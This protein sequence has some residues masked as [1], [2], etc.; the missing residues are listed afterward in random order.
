M[1]GYEILNFLIF[2]LRFFRIVFEQ[3]GERNRA[4]RKRFEIYKVSAVIINKIDTATTDFHNKSARN[5]HTVYNALIYKH[6]LFFNRQH[7][8]FDAAS[9]CDFVKETLLI[10]CS[11]DCRRS[12]G[13][14]FIDVVCVAKSSEHSKRFNGLRYSLRFQKT[15]A[16]EILTEPDA[17]FKFIEYDEI[18]SFQDIYQNHSRRIRADIDNCNFFHLV[19]L[20]TAFVN[21]SK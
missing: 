11:S 14:N 21:F 4:V 15:V 9:D 1:L 17:F 12:V 10:F 5:I 3:I 2:H 19:I 16:V 6:R 7:F 18:S 8:D 13:V 20:Q